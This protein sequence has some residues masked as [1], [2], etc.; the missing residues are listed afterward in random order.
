MKHL[1]FLNDT[2]KD[3]EWRTLITLASVQTLVSATSLANTAFLDSKISLRSRIFSL[4]A[5]ASGGRIHL[6]SWHLFFRTLPKKDHPIL[7][8]FKSH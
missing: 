7:T 3:S 4:Y 8:P 6:V 2:G 5:G 1:S